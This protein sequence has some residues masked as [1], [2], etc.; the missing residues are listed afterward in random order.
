MDKVKQAGDFVWR[1]RFWF[2]LGFALVLALW[3]YPSGARKLQV[4]AAVRSK[5]L[6]DAYKGVAAFIGGDQHPNPQTIEAVNT[7][8]GKVEQAIGT[9]WEELYQKQQTLMTWPAEV[10]ELFGKRPFGADLSDQSNR[11][12]VRYQRAFPEQLDEIFY[13]VDPIEVDEEDPN[14][15][16]GTIEADPS[17]LNSAEW[18]RTPLS[19]EAWQAQ[20][21]LWIQRALL[22]AIARCNEGAK[23]WH[24]AA[25]RRLLAI[26]M[27]AEALD[28]ETAA[29]K[30]A[31]VDSQG[32]PAG[33]GAEAQGGTAAPAVPGGNQNIV[34]HRYLSKSEQ[35]RVV[36]VFVSLLVD[37]ARIPEVLST[38]SAA[39][40][41]FAIHQV[42]IGQPDE[43]VRVPRE[44]LE[45]GMIGT[46][47]AREDAVFNTLQVDI[48]AWMRL[49]EMPPSLLAKLNPQDNA[50]PPADSP[51]P[52]AP[53]P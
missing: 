26:G 45:R 52:G 30:P 32:V 34:A 17:I 36:P 40:F 44:L 37:Q 9:T 1:Y 3:T 12:L 42:D 48:W 19:H 27:G 24:G 49:Y 8:V 20:E 28:A 41:G 35:Y 4:A 47:G 50:A 46:G 31:L 7:E 13:E 15:V 6:D 16:A 23:D 2:C 51:A 25:V 18:T 33:G 38:L 11:H 39:D 14:K 5:Q 53:Q 21:E 22:K 43:P 29:T 10:A